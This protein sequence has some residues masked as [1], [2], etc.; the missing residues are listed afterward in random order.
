MIKLTTLLVDFGLFVLIWLVQLIIY[1]S[2]QYIARD[3]FIAWHRQYTQR[4]SYIVVPLILVQVIGHGMGFYRVPNL[5]HGVCLIVIGMVFL[6]TFTRSVPCHASLGEWGRNTEQIT[7]LVQTNW[8]RTVGWSGVFLLS[9]IEY[10]RA[11]F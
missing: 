10:V 9:L 8:W 2:F 1:P 5:Y 3:E 11:G 7:R 4:V 6:V